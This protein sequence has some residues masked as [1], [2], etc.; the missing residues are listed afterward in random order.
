MSERE[1]VPPSTPS[2][3]RRPARPGRA[4][5]TPRAGRPPLVD[6]DAIIDAAIAVGFDRITS[7]AVAERLGVRQST[8]YR[9]VA[10]RD[11]LVAAAVDR[12]VEK[13]CWPV[14]GD[15]WRAYLLAAGDALWRL[16][17]AHPGLAE[18]VMTARVPLTATVRRFDRMAVDLL[19][20]GFDPHEAVLAVDLVWDLATEMAVSARRRAAGADP[21]SWVDRLDP[22]LREPVRHALAGPREWFLRK[23]ELAVDGCRL[24]VEAKAT[25]EPEAG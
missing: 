19:G 11:E 2:P 12:V 3:R 16:F 6:R 25:D 20:M 14:A 5:P 17:A 23:L 18:E 24:R 13:A 4:A 22:R 15:D 8:L 7:V 9:H 1:A 21:E 10:T